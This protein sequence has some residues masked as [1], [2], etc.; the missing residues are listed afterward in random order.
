MARSR[1]HIPALDLP[2]WLP[3]VMEAVLG[4]PPDRR[5]RIESFEPAVRKLA[6]RF[7]DEQRPEHEEPLH[8][9]EEERLRQAYFLYYTTSNLLKL[10]HPLDE[11]FLHPAFRHRPSLDVLEFGCGTGTA[12]LGF[13]A[14]REARGRSIHVAFTA[15][16]AVA[17]SLHF[18][19]RLLPHLPGRA[20]LRIDTATADLHHTP[21]LAPLRGGR[22]LV[23]LMNVVNELRPAARAALPGL[24]RE[25]LAPHGMVLL[26]EP[27]LRHTSRT[28]LALRDA[29]IATGWTA[30]SP[31]FRQADCPA[32]HEER[33]WCHHEVYWNRPQHIE[34][35]DA[36]LHNVKLSLKYTHVIMNHSGDTLDAT[37]GAPGACGRVVSALFEEKGRTRAWV[38]GPAGRI[39]HMKN[40]RDTTEANAAFDRLDRQAIVRISGTVPRRN[41][42]QITRDSTVTRIDTER[43]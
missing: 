29:M 31:C 43:V 4:F 27:A 9:Y 36:L 41:D 37:L 38:C 19:E 13:E 1:I 32:L 28:L 24:L 30:W 8:Y 34:W 7:T 40:T 6:D 2:A 11:L 17:G 35:L 21:T 25:L 15:T 10:A 23:I 5:A 12:L 18:V 26:L 33:D 22:D 20:S 3:S 42:E 39:Q 14:W 16:D